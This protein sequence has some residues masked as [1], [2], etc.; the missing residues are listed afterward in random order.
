MSSTHV[1]PEKNG[2]LSRENVPQV[3]VR[4][5]KVFLCS[6]CETL[7]EV[8]AQVVGRMMVVTNQSSQQEPVGESLAQEKPPQKESPKTRPPQ[9]KRP[10]QPVPARSEPRRI[11][12]IR[13]PSTGELERAFAWVSFHLKLLGLQGTEAKR[14]KRLRK[15]Y[16]QRQQP[17]S[18]QNQ[19]VK[20]PSS[21]PQ[22]PSKKVP[23]RGPMGLRKPAEE[24]HSG[25]DVSV[26]TG[27]NPPSSQAANSVP[28][29][30]TR[31]GLRRSR[32][33]KDRGPP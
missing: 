2:A 25:A 26:P 7:V 8:P 10:T 29:F 27:Q 9:P 15:Q 30:L 20:V 21:R 1:Q 13:V 33:A 5:G 6:A 32:K 28:K 17:A 18:P 22:R 31:H 11:D 12:G 14:L 24:S 16:K 19:P 4:A 23:A 3:A